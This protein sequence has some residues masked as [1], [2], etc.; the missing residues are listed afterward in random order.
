MA[1]S[2]EEICCFYTCTLPV[3]RDGESFHSRQV[4]ARPRTALFF[5]HVCPAKGFFSQD[6]KPRLKGVHHLPKATGPN[7]SGLGHT[8]AYSVP[9]FSSSLMPQWLSWTLL[10]HP[11]II[12]F[13]LVGGTRIQPGKGMARFLCPHPM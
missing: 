7:V 12:H 2:Q 4:P 10:G 3:R 13:M 5:P 9:G 1:T 8:W 6:K 11:L